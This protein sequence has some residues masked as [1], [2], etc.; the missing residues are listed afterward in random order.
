MRA[1]A[2]RWACWTSRGPHGDVPD[3]GRG[4]RRRALRCSYW[5]RLETTDEGFATSSSRDQRPVAASRRAQGGGRSGSA[6]RQGRA[7]QYPMRRWVT[8]LPS[9]R[10][11]KSGETR[12]LLRRPPRRLGRSVASMSPYGLPLP[13]K[14]WTRHVD[15]RDPSGSWRQGLAP[16]DAPLP[17]HPRAHEASWAIDNTRKDRSLCPIAG[18]LETHGR[19]TRGRS[20]VPV[21]WMPVGMKP[22]GRPRSVEGYVLYPASLVPLCPTAV[23]VA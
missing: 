5:L 9:I 13:A 12:S 3:V 14:R 20:T 19:T 15:F 16:S 4:G 2:S 7:R 6:R 8:A 21:T 1:S 18:T 11:S 22:H 23:R 17:R 10:L